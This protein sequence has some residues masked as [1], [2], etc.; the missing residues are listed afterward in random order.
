M[1]VGVAVVIAA[2]AGDDANALG[3]QAGAVFQGVGVLSDDH[4]AGVAAPPGEVAGARRVIAD[5]L[6]HL[7]ELAAHRHDNV[8]E[9]EIFHAGVPVGDL[10]PEHGLQMRLN[11]RDLV[12]HHGDLS[13]SHAGSSSSASSASVCSPSLGGWRRMLAGVFEYFTGGRRLK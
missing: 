6:Q 7:Q 8:G 12:G 10:Q 4:V 1:E 11:R 9:A 5:G 13:Q 2:A 3:F